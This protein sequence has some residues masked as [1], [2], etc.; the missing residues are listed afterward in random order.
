[1]TNIKSLCVFFFHYENNH[2]PAMEQH[3]A[4]ANR[5]IKLSFSRKL[6]SIVLFSRANPW[7]SVI[8]QS[9]CS[10]WTYLK[11]QTIRGL[12]SRRQQTCTGQHSNPWPRSAIKH[13]QSALTDPTCAVSIN[14]SEIVQTFYTLKRKVFLQSLYF[15]YMSKRWCF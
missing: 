8:E 7:S 2:Q 14:T 15:D 12:T 3:L 11:L 4:C 9:A 6:V 5:N 13:L 1:M 10:F